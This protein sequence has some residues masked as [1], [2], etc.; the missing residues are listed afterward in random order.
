M[1]KANYA[2][3]AHI[4]DRGRPLS[5]HNLDIWL[6]LINKY[7]PHKNNI[8]LLDLGCGTGRFAIPFAEKLSYQVYGADNS[9]EM[10]SKAKEKD[11]NK[12]VEWNL[13][14]A[15]SLTYLNQYFDV[16][17]MS[18]LLHHIDNPKIVIKECFRV[19]KSGG[20]LF[21]RYGAWDDI[22]DD[23]EHRFFPEAVEIDKQRTPT[24][25][26]IEKML[27]DTGFIKVKS[28]TLHQMT[29]KNAF[30]RYERNKLKPT[31]V[32]TMINTEDFNQGMERF[33]D[34]VIRNHLDEWL[35]G[36]KLTL[37]FGWVK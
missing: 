15:A 4:Y 27:K 32:L 25:L 29:W 22:R 31:S 18:H 7:V 13:Q 35:I 11:K 20:I 36:D 1:R 33:H 9:E 30:E 16:V 24:K 17:F 23:P 8:I 34:Y 21:N 2:K 19:L 26:K 3:I 37:T 6:S 14:D 28:I 12:L 5:G 10:L